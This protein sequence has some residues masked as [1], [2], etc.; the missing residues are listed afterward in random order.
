M[1]FENILKYW[2]FA[3]KK[4]IL[5]FPL[6]FRNSLKNKKEVFVKHYTYAPSYMPLISSPQRL[7]PI[8]LCSPENVLELLI[9]PKNG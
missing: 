8:S 1:I 4:Q 9:M 2:A 7:K 6:Y 3:P 5:H